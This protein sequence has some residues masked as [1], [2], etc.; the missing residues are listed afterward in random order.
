MIQGLLSQKPVVLPLGEGTVHAVLFVSGR[1]S[2]EGRAVFAQVW[3]MGLYRPSRTG[4]ALSICTGLASLLQTPW[5]WLTGLGAVR[6]F[7]GCTQWCLQGV[8]DVWLLVGCNNTR[9]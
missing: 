3:L 9:L 1:M 5:Q 6:G 2:V 8:T 4:R 7:P